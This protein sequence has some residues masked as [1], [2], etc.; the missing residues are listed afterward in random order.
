MKHNNKDKIHLRINNGDLIKAKKKSLKSCNI[1]KTCLVAQAMK[2][3]GFKFVNVKTNL[4]FADK[5]IY[6]ISPSGMEITESF[7]HN[8]PKFVGKKFTL[9]L[10]K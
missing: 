9:T 8:W 4:V 3:N 10:M 2:R 7:I 5:K 6:D 1:C